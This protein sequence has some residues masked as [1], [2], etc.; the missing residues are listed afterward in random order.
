MNVFDA[1]SKVR[2]GPLGNGVEDHLTGLCGEVSAEQPSVDTGYLFVFI[3]G[4]VG[5]V[6]VWID[7]LQPFVA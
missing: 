4:G 3:R 1:G 2:I 6:R 7:R 5:R